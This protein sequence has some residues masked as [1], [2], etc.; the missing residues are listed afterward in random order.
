MHTA[1]YAL[2]AD[3]WW[4]GAWNPDVVTHAVISISTVLTWICLVLL[5]PSSS[6][7]LVRFRIG[8]YLVHAV[9]KEQSHSL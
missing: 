9:P 7:A 2:L 6:E 1:G 3:F 5:F 4:Q 8:V